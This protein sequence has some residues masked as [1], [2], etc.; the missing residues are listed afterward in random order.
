MISGF[1]DAEFLASDSAVLLRSL[2]QE[3]SLENIKDISPWRFKAPL[4]PDMAACKEGREIN[5]DELVGY[6]QD[7]LKGPE[8]YKL[9]E[10]V[11][12]VMVPLDNEHTVLDWIAALN[13]P[14]IVVV[15]SYLGSISHS[16]TSIAALEAKAIDITEI[17]IS[18]SPNSTVDLAETADVLRRFLPGRRFRQLPRSD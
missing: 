9:I 12:G 2:G 1:D 16:L 8:N 13:I 14:A 7:L 17:V 6:C 4:S 3:P 10:G 18:E 5:F 11:G 15:G